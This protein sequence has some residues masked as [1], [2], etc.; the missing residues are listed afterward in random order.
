MPSS[1]IPP[2]IAFSELFYRQVNALSEIESTGFVL[3]V[4]EIY[5]IY[6]I[7]ANGSD[8]S[9]YV[10]LA[11]DYGGTNELVFLSTK[12][13]VSITNDDLENHQIVGDGV[14]KLQIVLINNGES[15]SPYIGGYVE[16]VK[17]EN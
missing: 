14:K 9:C 7:R 12:G 16:L 13:D 2:R 10:V 6:H 11:L 4:N 17:I 5:A 1:V 3:P 8:P 15:S